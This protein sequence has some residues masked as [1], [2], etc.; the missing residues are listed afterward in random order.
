MNPIRIIFFDI[1]GTL[2]DMQKKK[3]SAKTVETL[4]RLRENGIKICIA[5]GRSPMTLPDFGGA[6]FDAFL[7]FNGSLCYAG[8]KTIFSN[9]ID[10]KEVQKL[11]RNAAALHRP[12]AVATG[13]RL[14]ANG[15]DQD[16]TDYFA[17]ANEVPHIA[18]DFEEVCREEI[19]QLMMG[20]RASD[21]PAILN[22]VD[23]AKI[24]AWW[25]RAVDIIPASGG[26][27]VGIEKMLEF[28]GIDRSQ[29]LAFGD[30]NNDIEMFRAVGTGVAMQ[31]ASAE[32][33]AVAKE[34]CGDV[35]Q[36]GICSYCVEHG[37]I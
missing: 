19:Y 9:P 4:H 34:V 7:T 18:D 33:K 20:C 32:L 17:I 6:E 16:L 31:N 30:G 26:K 10:P 1:D 5:T 35:S 27:G 13:N 29:A 37:L 8:E 22:G 15:T 21:Y 23:G 25:D 28:Y 24:A 12:V 2:I 3:I 11:I 36:D 14:V